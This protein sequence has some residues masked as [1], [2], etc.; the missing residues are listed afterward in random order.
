MNEDDAISDLFYR[1]LDPVICIYECPVRA[2][3]ECQNLPKASY[4]GDLLVEEEGDGVSLTAIE[5]RVL[6]QQIVD[7]KAPKVIDVREPGEFRRSHVPGSDLVPLSTII[8]TTTR[9]GYD[10][11]IVLVCR[12]GRRSKRAAA[13]LKAHGYK[14]IKVLNGG[15]A[16]WEEAHLLTAVEYEMKSTE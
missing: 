2:F 5:P 8:T 10:E 15:M 14:D 6:W 16:A 1:E 7:K 11:P 4:V 13:V 12:S 9:N 3:K